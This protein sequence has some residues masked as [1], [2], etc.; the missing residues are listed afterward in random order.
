MLGLGV[1]DFFIIL[2]EAR[3]LQCEDDAVIWQST[4]Q[5]AR[6]HMGLEREVNQLDRLSPERLRYEL[7][8]KAAII[9]GNAY[10]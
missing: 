3:L 10:N 8:R 1:P 7:D 5:E 6:K 4:R 2:R 9:C